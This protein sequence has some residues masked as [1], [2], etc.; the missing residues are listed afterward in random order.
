M[1]RNR[2]QGINLRP[3]PLLSLLIVSALLETAWTIYI[4]WRLPRHYV[5][6]HWATA[7]VGL[8]AA[9]VIMLLLAAWAAWRRRA[10]LILFANSAGTLLLVDAWF[11][12]TTARHG[13]FMESLMMVIIVEIPAAVVLFWITRRSLQKMAHTITAEA[14]LAGAPVRKITFELEVFDDTPTT[15]L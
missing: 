1:P 7:W 12:V 3:D 9:E 13:D 15:E 4:G 14:N 6:N 11:D 2:H 10:L 8:D 5:A